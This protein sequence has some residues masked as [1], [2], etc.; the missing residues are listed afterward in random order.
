MAKCVLHTTTLQAD[1]FKSAKKLQAG[2]NVEGLLWP[3]SSDPW[4]MIY[5]LPAI[6]I[7]IDDMNEM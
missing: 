6:L 4:P 1:F 2:V 5:V 7:F 3:I